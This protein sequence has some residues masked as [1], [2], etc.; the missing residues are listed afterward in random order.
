MEMY[1]QSLILIAGALAGVASTLGILAH[2]K[3][4]RKRRASE[5]R[6]VISPE[7]NRIRPTVQLTRPERLVNP[8]DFSQISRFESTRQDP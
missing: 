8:R 4:K 2:L 6:I 3:W 7:A 1:P 5:P